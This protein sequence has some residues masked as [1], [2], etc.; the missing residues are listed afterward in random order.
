MV[1]NIKIIQ[2][3]LHMKNKKNYIMQ[4]Y[5]LNTITILYQKNMQKKIFLFQNF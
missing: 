2:N 5:K 1:K 3:N 4:N